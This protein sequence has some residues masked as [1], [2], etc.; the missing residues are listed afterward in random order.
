MSQSINQLSAAVS[1]LQTQVEDVDK[2]ARRGI[3]AAAAAISSIPVVL[4]RG[5]TSLTLGSG[6]YRDA[7]PCD[8]G[9][10]QNRDH[11]CH[12]RR[13]RCLRAYFCEPEIPHR[14]PTAWLRS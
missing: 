6:F 7:G 9:T 8:D 2:R 12:R 5:Q 3:A 1:A 11:D 13:A 14:D 10:C 4:N